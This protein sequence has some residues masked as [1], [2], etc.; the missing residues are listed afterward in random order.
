MLGCQSVQR[1]NAPVCR[2]S[3]DLTDDALLQL[4]LQNKKAIKSF[5]EI[6]DK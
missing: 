5:T 1:N 4:N 6:C 3:F 2:V